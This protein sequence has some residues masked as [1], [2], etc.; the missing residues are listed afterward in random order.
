MS[1][2]PNKMNFDPIPV[3]GLLRPELPKVPDL[4]MQ[5][6]IAAAKSQPAP[7]EPLVAP[8]TIV[9]AVPPFSVWSIFEPSRTKGVI[10]AGIVSLL[11]GAA[12]MKF[13][14]PPKAPTPVAQSEPEPSAPLPPLNPIR[15]P[16]TFVSVPPVVP[17]TVAPIVSAPTVPIATVPVPAV[18][19]PITS[20]LPEIKLPPL[21]SGPVAVSPPPVPATT[22]STTPGFLPL[23]EL[24]RTGAS[25]STAPAVP[26]VP[27]PVAKPEEKPIDIK[28]PELVPSG[29]TTPGI[30]TAITLPSLTAP[31][32][33]PAASPAPAILSLPE[34]KVDLPAVT[35][36]PGPKVEPTK[37]IKVE[38][39][40]LTALPVPGTTVPPAKPIEIGVPPLVD[41]GVSKPKLEFSTPLPESKPAT[42]EL[43][44][45]SALP[46]GPKPDLKLAAPELPAVSVL[47]VARPQPAPSNAKTEY[48]VDLHYVKSG[49]TWAA[50]SKLHFGDERYGDALKGYNQN[51][52]LAQ[53]QRAEVPPIHVLRKN[54]ATLIGRPVEKANEWGSITPS[55]ATL[56]SN[57]SKRTVTG[58]GYKIYSVPAGGKTLKEIAADA[59][60]DEGRWGMV[61]DTNPKLVPDKPVPE[62]TKIYLTSQSKIGD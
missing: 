27:V 58:N 40:A 19:V 14:W 8:A 4:P 59:Y 12:T 32:T 31:A 51:A 60:G 46:T 43:P 53:L 61:W 47:P 39:P 1:N 36:A 2:D 23:P 28:L 37:D 38:P 25:D 55:S 33:T 6:A 16:E 41:A 48:D 15:S 49:D 34:V 21:T 57:D 62:G 56:T 9:P 18:T 26:T 29:G 13:I 52:S 20:G 54:F 30:P 24:I 3:N 22:T 50:I 17:L 42:P 11:G 5:K 10:A 7:A 35:A 45:L 44:V